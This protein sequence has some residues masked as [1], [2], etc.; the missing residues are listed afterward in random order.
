MIFEFGK[1]QYYFPF[2]LFF[3]YWSVCWHSFCNNCIDFKSIWM[4]HDCTDIAFITVLLSPSTAMPRYSKVWHTATVPQG[5][6]YGVPSPCALF[7]LS[8]ACNPTATLFNSMQMPSMLSSGLSHCDHWTQ[9]C[10]CYTILLL[11]IP[12]LRGGI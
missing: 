12:V 2:S 1:F 9:G 6:V 3:N 8:V 10:V 11:C 4:V 5:T 7:F